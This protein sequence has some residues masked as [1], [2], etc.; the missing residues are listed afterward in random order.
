MFAYI[1]IAVGDILIGLV[2]QYFKSR[3]K[4]LYVFYALTIISGILFF[5]PP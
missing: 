2:S 5:S 4:A 1:G 3:K